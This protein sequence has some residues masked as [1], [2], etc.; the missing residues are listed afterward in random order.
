MASLEAVIAEV[1]HIEL[2]IMRLIPTALPAPLSMRW[3]AGRSR[4]ARLRLGAP[5]APEQN[6]DKCPA[7]DLAEWFQITKKSAA[8]ILRF[9]FRVA[10]STA[11]PPP[12]PSAS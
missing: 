8:V 10:I 6:S 3:S 5:L 2:P 7:L 12:D 9:F 11:L 4:P 1:T